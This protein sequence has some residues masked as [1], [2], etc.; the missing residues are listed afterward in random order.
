VRSLAPDEVALV[1]LSLAG[2]GPVSATQVPPLLVQAVV[3]GAS[4]QG[5]AARAF[6]RFLAA[7]AGNA[8][9]RGC[10][11]SSEQ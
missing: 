7:G 4:R 2:S 8:A 11:R 10:G 5:D 1:P 6:V 9:F 3:L